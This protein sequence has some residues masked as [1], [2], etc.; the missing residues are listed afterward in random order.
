[1]DNFVTL[2]QYELKKI[3]KRKMVRITTGIL[4]LIAVYMGVSESLTTGHSKTNGSTTVYMNGFEFVAFEKENAQMISGRKIDD[5]LLEEVKAAYQRVHVADKEGDSMTTMY[6]KDGEDA[7]QLFKLREQYTEIYRYVRNIMG[8]YEAIHSI[9]ED[10]LYQ[11]RNEKLQSLWEEQF[12]TE[13]EKAYWLEKEDSIEKPFVYSY[14]EG[15]STI[16]DEFLSLIFMLSLG[17]AICLSNVFSDE[18]LRK[19]DQLI[20]CSKYGKKKLFYA[21]IAAG[22]SFGTAI[23]AGLLCLTMLSTFSVYGVE[24]FDT[25]IQVY[26]P[27]CSWNLTMGQAVLFMSVVYLFAA[28]F[29]SIM[30]MFL[31]EALENGIAVMGLMT[32]GMLFTMVGDIPYRF[33]MVSQLYGLLPTVLLRVWQ[34]WDDRLLKPFGVYL[35][36]FQSALVIWL[37][38][39][40]VLICIGSRLYRNGQIT[41]R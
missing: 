39:S 36:N 18:H 29:L 4:M 30:T 23:G 7:E 33:R 31:S 16:L 40:V 12:L 32:G 24:G 28:V 6:M 8:N 11:K 2:Y 5:A 10:A 25:A 14:A 35:A 41:G 38:I 20:L 26:L 27:V 21:K 3:W 13:E 17:I 34:L 15:W 1:M 9:S 22:V 37:A 19:T